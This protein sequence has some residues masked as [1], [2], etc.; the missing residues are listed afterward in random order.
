MTDKR[1]PREE[2]TT[3][4]ARLSEENAG[5]PV[6]V[7]VVNTDVGDQA[8]A[9]DEPLVAIDADLED[10]IDDA[11]IITVGRDDDIF[12]HTVNDPVN[13]WLR[14]DDEGRLLDI[15]IESREEGRTLIEFKDVPRVVA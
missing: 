1:L 9:E 15:D 2:W 7:R 6:D 14:Y 8:L 13:I 3:V 5:R 12:G 4:L 10:G 11:I